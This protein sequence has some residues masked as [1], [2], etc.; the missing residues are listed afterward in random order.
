MDKNKADKIIETLKALQAGQLDDASLPP[1]VRE[2]IRKAS[3]TGAQVVA[4]S[5][6]QL[7]ELGLSP[8]AL[9]M[10]IGDGFTIEASSVRD[11]TDPRYAIGNSY[12]KELADREFDL[13]RLMSDPSALTGGE[14]IRLQ[15]LI[16]GNVDEIMTIAKRK[17]EQ[18]P[19]DPMAMQVLK[20]L[21]ILQTVGVSNIFDALAAGEKRLRWHGVSGG[22]RNVLQQFYSNLVNVLA[23]KL[24]VPATA[25]RVITDQMAQEIPLAPLPP[26]K[27]FDEN[28][29]SDFMRNAVITDPEIQPL[30]GDML[31]AMIAAGITKLS[32]IFSQTDGLQDLQD[33]TGMSD[34][35]T[36]LFGILLQQIDGVSIEAIDATLELAGREDHE[37][38]R[39]EQ[40]KIQP[41]IMLDDPVVI[42]ALG[43]NLITTLEIS[44][45]VDLHE[46][47]GL[48]PS[49]AGRAI[50]EALPVQ[51]KELIREVCRFLNTGCDC[52]SCNEF[53]EHFVKMNPAIGEALKVKRARIIH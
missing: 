26:E 23:M 19:N 34:D 49:E 21:A 25:V 52:E 10:L 32:D 20:T 31:D 41:V 7:K 39:V 9:D 35:Q 8:D 47:T 4:V 27:V 13:M 12:A 40:A 37:R 53:R 2:M 5:G 16:F 18:E 6:D 36:A 44:G 22:P 51:Q 14:A 1:H 24:R 33:K 45:I 48:R 17:M 28:F 3:E 29:S 50:A 11:T 43:T 38:E 15:A 30:V 42:A 46:V